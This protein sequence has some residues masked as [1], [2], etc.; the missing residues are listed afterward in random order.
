MRRP[1]MVLSLLLMAQAALAQGL[2]ESSQ[3][4]LPQEVAR[5]APPPW[6]IPHFRLL[7]EEAIRR[8]MTA[9]FVPLATG[10]ALR[11]SGRTRSLPANIALGF[12]APP[13]R[14]LPDARDLIDFFPDGSS[15]G[16]G[17]GITRNG[18]RRDILVDWLTGRISMHDR[19][20]DRRS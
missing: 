20:D 3:G 7:R 10:Y 16:G 9:T 12:A 5:G 18:S 2:P 19:H 13:A 4:G 14:L 15:T 1:T 11:P 17:L 8:D 6:L